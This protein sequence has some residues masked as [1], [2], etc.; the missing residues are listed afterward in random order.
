MVLDKAKIHIEDF[1]Q[2]KRI[3]EMYDD[4]SRII[5]RRIPSLSVMAKT[6]EFHH[7]KKMLAFY[8]GLIKRG[9]LCFDVG[10]NVGKF[11]QIFLE[12]GAKV[13]CIEPQ[14]VC[15]QQLYQSFGHDTNVIII[16]KALGEREGEADFWISEETPT[17]STLCVE[18][19]ESELQ[20]EYKWTKKVRTPITTLDNLI[21]M[22]GLPKYCKIDVEGFELQVLKGLSETIKLVS[23]EF[24]K[25]NLEDT[26]KCINRL[27]HIGNAEF[28]CMLHE[29]MEFLFQKWVSSKELYEKIV[30]TSYTLH[31][32]FFW[33][34][35]YARFA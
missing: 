29:S 33:G 4:L 21:V 31:D 16:P 12:L 15:L 3:I 5:G 30:E 10:A 6:F 28:N 14:E 13:V 8:S 23:F 26:K 34:D 2:N 1:A 19:K 24:G 27:L 17:M 35:I 25:G 7:K 32:R 22:Y 11:T 20:Q 18:R 9:D